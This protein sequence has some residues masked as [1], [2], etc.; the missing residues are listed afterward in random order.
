MSNKRQAVLH[1]LRSPWIMEDRHNAPWQN[2]WINFPPQWAKAEGNISDINKAHSQ[3]M[4]IWTTVSSYSPL[5]IMV[6]Q[7]FWLQ[8]LA[9]FCLFA[10]LFVFVHQSPLKSN[11]LI[12]MEVHIRWGDIRG[13]IFLPCSSAS[14]ELEWVAVGRERRRQEGNSHLSWGKVTV[15]QPEGLVTFVTDIL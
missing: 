2:R 9:F 5:K 1:Q 12:Q 3:Y 10:C 4:F 13:S 11:L 7:S 15:F 14:P 8:R 6:F